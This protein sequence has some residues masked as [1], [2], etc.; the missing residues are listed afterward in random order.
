VGAGVERGRLEEQARALG[1]QD[2]VLFAGSVPNTEL[3]AWF[4]AADLS[5]LSSSREGLPNVVLESLACGTPVVA[6]R[7]G[8]V[9]EVATD[10]ASA[11]LVDVRDA[12]HIA[13]EIRALLAA[14]PSRERVREHASRFGWQATS[15]A[16]LNLFR[17]IVQDAA[18]A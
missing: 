11:R 6:T 18:H 7:V 12:E 14:R 15:A 8:G 9:P 10:P 5:I 16:Q 2:K 1:V 13:A 17:S 3:P 4:S